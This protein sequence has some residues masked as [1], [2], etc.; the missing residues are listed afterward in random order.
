MGYGK[1]SQPLFVGKP[2][3]PKKLPPVNIPKHPFLAPQG[4]NGMHSDSYISGTYQWSGPL[5]NNPRVKSSS[6]SILGGLMA[7]LAVDSKGRL[8]GVSGNL[9]DFKLLLLDPET[10]EILASH[11]LPQR[12]STRKFWR[13]LDMRVIMKDTS[14]GAYFHLDKNDRPIVVN[15]NRVI[16]IFKIEQ[17][18]AKFSWKV[19][20][21]YD[22]NTA[23]SKNALVT[24]AMPDWKGRIWFVTRSAVVGLV[25]TDTGIIKT[26]KLPGEEIQNAMAVAEDGVYIVSDHALYRFEA[27]TKT[28][29][30][31]FTWREKYDRGTSI[32][33]GS[34]NQ[35]CGTTPTL[36]SDGL[37]AIT[38]NSDS[39]D[40]VCI[41][42][43]LPG[44]RG[45]RLICKIPVFDENRS[46]SENSL[47][48]YGKSVIVENNYFYTSGLPTDFNPKT[49]AG[50]T[51]IDVNKNNRGCKVIWES[52]EASQTVVPKMSTGNGLIYLYTRSKSTPDSI[53]SWYLTAL[54][55]RTG[56]TVFKI[57]TG[58]GQLWNNTWAPITIAPDGTL[59]VGVYNGIISIKDGETDRPRRE[60]N[61]C[62]YSNKKNI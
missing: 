4:K 37:I 3:L 11:S 16:Q 18:N 25:Y 12:E 20:K 19:E 13:T 62:I 36:L 21:E 5:G 48:G 49:H 15:S 9:F 34:V 39:R 42:N 17:T 44:Q 1:C 41:Y 59:Y 2:A 32:K 30:P 8:I 35:G 40:N 45:R 43:R 53:L 6:L 47:I 50:V 10:L 38:D 29:V 22:L 51:R 31:H 14:G 26:L 24:D 23:L 33:P 27:D 57:F 55:F 58:T 28:G 7:T 60:I 56:K 46:V 52:R 61:G 54:D